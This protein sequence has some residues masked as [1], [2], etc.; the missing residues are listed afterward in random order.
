MGLQRVGVLLIGCGLLVATLSAVT[1][2]ATAGST[3]VR[4]VDHDPTYSL[5]E[6]DL[7]DLEVRYT[8]GCNTISVQPLIPAGGGLVVLGALVGVIGV[9][10]QRHRR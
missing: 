2:G 4:C 3:D 7:A 5:S 9:G 1:L 8:N 6:L 10:R